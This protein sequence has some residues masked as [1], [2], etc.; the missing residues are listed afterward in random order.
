LHLFDRIRKNLKTFLNKSIELVLSSFK[1][2]HKCR[3]LKR[4][5]QIAGFGSGRQRE[6]HSFDA[7]FA[8]PFA[9]KTQIRI[10]AKPVPR[11]AFSYALYNLTEIL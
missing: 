4:F 10:E 2:P 9:I 11:S 8:G 6:S 5:G 3:L 1:L 7:F